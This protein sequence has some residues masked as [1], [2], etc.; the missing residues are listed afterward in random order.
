MYLTWGLFSLE[1]VWRVVGPV[2]ITS[3]ALSR[4]KVGKKVWL[5]TIREVKGETTVKPC[6]TLSCDLLAHI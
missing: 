5:N 2:L 3:C 4:A 6:P 1:V